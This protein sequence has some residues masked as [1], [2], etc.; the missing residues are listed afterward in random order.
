VSGEL[1][2]R[3]SRQAAARRAER[4]GSD[5]RIQIL[6]AL[7]RGSLRPRR[8]APRRAGERCVIAVDW[9]HPQWLA[10]AVLIVSL[11]CLDA[12]MT[13][14]LVEHGARE[15]NPLMAPLV[16][17]SALKFA[18]VKIA[19]TA[20]SVVLLTQ[21]A[22]VRAFGRLPAGVV[23]YTVLVVYAALIFYE[24]GLLNAP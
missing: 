24:Y 1:Q 11:S 21:L 10:I 20:A 17:G 18:L 5:R 19:L 8:R 16:A 23:L 7:V 9:H 12:F 13:L 6:Q 14:M 3:E 4:R 22:R 15:A 2:S